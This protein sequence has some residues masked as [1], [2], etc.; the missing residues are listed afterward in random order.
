MGRHACKGFIISLTYDNIV[1]S[2]VISERGPREPNTARFFFPFLRFMICA[3]VIELPQ[4][5]LYRISTEKPIYLAPNAV[6]APQ[7][8]A[9][10]Y[11]FCENNREIMRKQ[12][13]AICGMSSRNLFNYFSLQQFSIN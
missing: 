12:W 11:F 5:R 2:K 10:Y 7:F 4:S 1:L 6:L 8:V 9:Y 3:A 13:R